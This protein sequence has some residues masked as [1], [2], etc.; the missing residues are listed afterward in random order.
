[1]KTDPIFPLC[2]Y[3]LHK[4]LYGIYVHIHI[5]KH[6]CISRMIYILIF[7]FIYIVVYVHELPHF[8]SFGLSVSNHGSI[9]M[10]S[11]WTV[12]GSRLEANSYP[13]WKRNLST[14]N[15][16]FPRCYVRFREYTPWK[17]NGWNLQITHFRKEKNDLPGLHDY[18]PC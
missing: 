13:R 8:F 16:P 5:H 10:A 1:M 7:T 3:N 4:Y 18:V 14:S 11:R 9:T 6:T 15:R 2:I 17:M 12:S